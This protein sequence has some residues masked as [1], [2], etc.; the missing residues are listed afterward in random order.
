MNYQEALNW[1]HAKIKLG[2][3]PGLKRMEWLLNAFDNP[4]RHLPAVHVV[5]TNG[6][7][8]TVAY[9]QH[10]FRQSA[11]RVGAFTSPFIVDFR[12][13]IAIDGQMISKADLISLVELVQPVVDSLPEQTDFAPASEFEVVCLMMFLYFTRIN[14]VDIAIIE[15]GIGGLND[16]TNMFHA[17]AVVCPSIGLDHQEMLG[18][19]HAEI[20]YQK[21]SVL[22]GGEAFIFASQNQSVTQVF[23]EI[24]QQKNS[25]AFHLGTDFT[26][27]ESHA[28]FDFSYK[29]QVLKNITLKM[30]GSHQRQNAS[31]AIMVSLILQKAYPKVSLENIR[32][33][34]A[35]TSWV[36]RTEF[37]I[38]QLMLDGAH[39]NESIDALVK[40]I[41]DDYADK[42]MHILFAAIKSKPLDS[43]LDKLS[44]L[45]SVFVTTFAFPK[46]LQ[47]DDYPQGYDR[48][49]D[50]HSFLQEARHSSCD[51]LYLVTG[52]LYFISQVRQDFIKMNRVEE[53]DRL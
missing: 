4:Q 25:R 2:P 21:A 33:A 51:N 50:Y 44:S 35:Q 16:A 23:H 12:E 15:A 34:I 38:P 30:L 24:C 28:S 11:Y 42:K 3:K 40:L 27:L 46:A 8:S 13:R 32:T 19:T 39:N 1:I 6:K 52:S 36:G 26:I 43:M 22:K 10:I 31:L 37:L 41:Q 17:L 29:E 9:L 49:D 20:A 53:D 18:K 5:G 48:I 45:G 14:P 7:G 47:L